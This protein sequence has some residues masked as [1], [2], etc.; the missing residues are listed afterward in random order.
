MKKKIL[1]IVSNLESG[2]VSKSMSTLLTVID[3]SRFDVSVLIIN[4]TGVFMSLLP[5][6]VTVLKD[7]K[8]AL[9]FSKFPNNLL[10][11]IAKGHLFAALLRFVAAFVMI[12]NKGIGAKLLSK[13]ILTLHDHYDLA[14]DFNGQQQLYY[15]V[16]RVQATV[17]VSFFH[18]DYSKWDYYYEMDREYF[19]K[20]DK[21]FTISDIC[22]ASLQKYFPNEASKIEL[23]ENISSLELINELGSIPIDM[24]INSIVTVGHLTKLKGTLLALEVAEILK[25]KGIKFQWYFVGQ[26]SKDFDYVQIVKS[27]GLKEYIHFVGVTPNPYPYIKNATIMVHLS[28]FE[29]KSIALDE[30]KLLAKPIVVTNFSTVN[31]Q[32]MH[33]YNA[34]ITSFEP[35]TVAQDVSDLLN[36]ANLRTKYSKNLEQD[37]KSNQCELEKLYQLLH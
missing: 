22:V 6:D 24:G 17:K 9:F 1:F 5:S 35:T 34:T 13:G 10:S 32:F 3:K 30:A 36:D 8:T 19:S 16:D 37:R 29:G 12:F 14:V 33:R 23:F 26:D 21:I 25:N 28:S 7:A 18:S 15:L 2:G 27:K 4:P 20:V 11:L 31:D